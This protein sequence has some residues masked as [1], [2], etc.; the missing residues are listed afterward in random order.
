MRKTIS[1]I[2]TFAIILNMFSILSLTVYAENEKII[3]RDMFSYHIYHSK[4]YISGYTGNSTV[5]TFPGKIGGYE[6]VGL[7]KPTSL[8]PYGNESRISGLESVTEIKINENI[9]NI[10]QS[11]F[12]NYSNLKKVIIPYGVQKIG[13]GAFANCTNLSEIIFP[14]SIVS[15]GFNAFNNTSWYN[16]QRDGVVYAGKFVYNY[17]GEMPEKYTFKIKD[18]TF[19]IANLAFLNQENLTNI[20][21]PQ[22]LFCIGQNAFI[23]TTWYS[24]QNNGIVYVGKVVYSYKGD[25]PQDGTIKF[26]K[27]IMG[28]ADGA[29]F[30]NS[31]S[32]IDSNSSINLTSIDIPDTVKYIGDSAFCNC[33]NLLDLYLPKNV[34]YIGEFA[35]G[36]HTN[37]KALPTYSGKGRYLHSIY[38]STIEEYALYNRIGYKELAPK[39]ISEYMQK[40]GDFYYMP[41]DDGSVEITAYRG[42]SSDIVIPDSIN[43]K[44]VTKI[45]NH[46]FESNDYINTVTIPDTVKY[47]GEYSFCFCSNLRNI[48]FGAN[49]RRIEDFAF[50]YCNNLETV[51]ICDSVMSLGEYCF[52]DCT[53][54]TE[55]DLGKDLNRLN[56][57]AFSFC[58]NLKN[59]NLGDS[60]IDIGWQAFENCNNIRSIYIPDSV[61]NVGEYAF[62]NCTSLQSVYLRD[63]IEKIDS[64]AF[65][66][67]TPNY[68]SVYERLNRFT[69]YGFSG[70]EA[71]RYA[72]NHGIKFSVMAPIQFGKPQMNC[73]ANESIV[74]DLY[75]LYNNYSAGDVIYKSSDSDIASVVESDGDYNAYCKNPKVHIK[76]NNIGTAYITAQMPDGNSTT[77]T[78]QVT[79]GLNGI[80]VYSDYADLSVCN[81]SLIKIGA[82]VFNNGFQSDDISKLTYTVYD[83]SILEVEETSLHD[84]CRF[85]VAKAISPGTTYVSFSDSKTGYVTRVPVT[86]YEGNSMTFTVENVP[87]QRIE[88]Y[89]S[90]FYNVNGMYIDN[91]SYAKNNDDSCTV[92]FDVYNTKYIFGAVEIYSENGDI[93]D[94]VVIDKMTNN[95]GSIK[96]TV[97]D[98]CCDLA[99]DIYN[100]NLLTYRQKTNSSKITTVKVTI[101]KNGYINITNDTE[102]SAIVSSINAFDC[103]LQLKGLYGDIKGID[104]N[105]TFLPA[106]KMTKEILKNAVSL[107]CF[108]DQTKFS[109]ELLNGAFKKTLIGGE[110][111]GN[112]GETVVYNMQN[113]NLEDVCND[114]LLSCGFSVGESVFED[115][116]GIFGV[117]LKEMFTFG[118]SLNLLSEIISI[119]YSKNSGFITLQN[120]SGSTRNCLGVQV[121]TDTNFN[122]DTALKVFRLYADSELIQKIKDTH[123]KVYDLI[124]SVSNSTYNISM[125]KNG[126][127]TQIDKNVEVSIPISEELKFLASMGMIKVHRV[128]DDGTITDMKAKYK[129]ERLI[130]TTNH[131]SIYVVS[132]P[133]NMIIGDINSDGSVNA[134]DRMMLTRYL[135][136]WSGYEN[137]NKSV[138]DVN[139]DGE[140]NAKD[141]MI[142]TR[143]LA[144]WQDYETL[145]LK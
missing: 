92:S 101:P 20:Q 87:E 86:V 70:T 83:T 126:D 97:W 57:N 123:P 138:A 102:N 68:D 47:I 76:C 106:Q 29:F 113:L 1:I 34:A 49:I 10:Y 79:E 82:G 66:Y 115:M 109:K 130:F 104:L 80:R 144:K 23:G 140:V 136:K 4:A 30:D 62:V 111:V 128:E 63:N 8:D 24:N 12:A 27:N 18:G 77:M 39:E 35:F 46:A 94:A 33:D 25:I 145:P 99:S 44:A 131:F 67:Y 93:K 71:E 31:G 64:C 105:N 117:V 125:I 36:Y 43:S 127:E 118:D 90:N 103:I 110:A 61:L 38:N 22:S 132:V 129:D 41:L 9:K 53:S 75:I 81:G 37:G 6:V 116:A 42:Q 13:R 98:N 137:I 26:N 19:G 74:A 122:S 59:I 45:G 133:D 56:R 48:N 134:K 88:K 124:A 72:N 2:L 11:A 139:N 95:A 78:V 21:A 5:V 89:V 32:Y 121:K 120:Q 7:G 91:Y 60:I 54:L 58:R 73:R 52:S 55:V 119:S 100:G 112:F 142:L 114:A 50:R 84:N 65:G 141:R 143:H 135:A 40:Y 107:E 14:D 85:I 28:I 17:K 108:K 16:K 15:I 51:I 96:E 69:L 3:E